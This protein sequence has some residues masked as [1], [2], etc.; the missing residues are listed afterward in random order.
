M[1]TL[2]ADAS[3]PSLDETVNSHLPP[4]GGR[5]R[6]KIQG[7]VRRRSGLGFLGLLWYPAAG[8][9][10]FGDDDGG[11]PVMPVLPWDESPFNS[12]A[13]GSGPGGSL[14]VALSTLVRLR[15]HADLDPRAAR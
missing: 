5:I 9:L 12:L 4:R 7:Q 14:R 15:V 1:R 8:G 2:P 10:R 6:E 13:L 11:L 3:V